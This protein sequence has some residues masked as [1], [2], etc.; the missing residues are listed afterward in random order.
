MATQKTSKHTSC[1]A[2]A[3]RGH[4][5]AAMAYIRTGDYEDADA[6]LG[7]VDLCLDVIR[8]YVW[9]RKEAH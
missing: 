5:S 3:L 9:D 8:D 2:T 7:Y 1:Y 6:E 4:L